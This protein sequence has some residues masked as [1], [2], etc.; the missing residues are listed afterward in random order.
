MSRHKKAPVRRLD[1]LTGGEPDNIL[2]MRPNKTSAVY[3]KTINC[4]NPIVFTNYHTFLVSRRSFYAVGQ[5]CVINL[6]PTQS[7]SGDT[8]I[9]ACLDSVELGHVIG[10]V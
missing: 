4:N 6:N 5:S 2:E 7:Q 8:P 10:T 1:C 3:I 9:Q